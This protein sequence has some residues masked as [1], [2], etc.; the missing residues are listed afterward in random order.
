WPEQRHAVRAPHAAP[1][2]QLLTSNDVTAYNRVLVATSRRFGLTSIGIQHGMTCEPNGHSIVHV[3]ALA[4]WGK[5]TELWHRA[6]APQ[7]ARFIVTGN[8]RFDTLAARIRHSPEPVHSPLAPAAS[9]P[10]RPSGASAS[11]A[12]FTVCV[13]TGFVSDFTTGASQYENLLMID[14]VLQWAAGKDA[15]RVIHKLHPGEELACYRDAARALQ[16]DPL[17]L[18]TIG[19]PI[20]YDILERS[21]VLVASYSS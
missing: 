16:W 9:A 13:C 17:K 21:Q 5:E 14:T 7:K 18:T 10:T 6:Q 12:A 15:V 3:D 20:L 19:E 4:T 8:P 11:Q 2:G 1:R